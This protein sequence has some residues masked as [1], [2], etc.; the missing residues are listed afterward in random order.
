LKPE[1]ITIPGKYLFFLKY[2]LFLNFD[3]NYLKLYREVNNPEW[4]RAGKDG[5]S[6]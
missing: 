6:S 1:A 3:F 4:K 5:F 2:H